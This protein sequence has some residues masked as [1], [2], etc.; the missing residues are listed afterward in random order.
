MVAA[1]EDLADIADTVELQ[2]FHVNKLL[3]RLKMQLQLHLLR[4][5]KLPMQGPCRKQNCFIRLMPPW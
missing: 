4:W 5:R 2:I 1:L 3:W